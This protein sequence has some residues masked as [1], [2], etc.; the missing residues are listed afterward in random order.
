MSS[1]AGMTG[2]FTV[3]FMMYRNNPDGYKNLFRT[4]KCLCL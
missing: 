4:T 3:M 1:A 2:I